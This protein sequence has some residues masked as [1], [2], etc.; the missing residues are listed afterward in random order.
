MNGRPVSA[1][2]VDVRSP[3]WLE[4]AAC[5]APGA[6]PDAWFPDDDDTAAIE[7]AKAACRA[8]PVRLLCLARALALGEVRHGVWGGLDRWERRAVNRANVAC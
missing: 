8:C 3:A 5:R 2:G 7:A 4:S 1:R 6:N